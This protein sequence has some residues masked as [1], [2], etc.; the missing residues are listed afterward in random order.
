MKDDR[1]VLETQGDQHEWDAECFVCEGWGF[2]FHAGLNGKEVADF[3]VL[4]GSRLSG[5]VLD[6]DI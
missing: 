1:F 6:M 5:L 3:K 2:E 4:R